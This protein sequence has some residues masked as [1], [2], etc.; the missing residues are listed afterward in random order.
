MMG[1][2]GTLTSR[3]CTRIL[4]PSFNLDKPIDIG[5]YGRLQWSIIAHFVKVYASC[6][7]N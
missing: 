5:N 7:L 1:G 2:V 3:Y 6:Q 4:C